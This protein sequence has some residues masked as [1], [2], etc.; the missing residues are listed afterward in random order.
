[1]KSLNWIKACTISS[2]LAMLVWVS[3]VAAQEN[4]KM[5]DPEVAH[6]AVTANQI[7]IDHASIAKE[8][9]KNAEVLQ[10]AETMARDHKAVI[11]QAVALVQKLGVTPEDNAV[12]QKL[13]ADAEAARKMLRSKSGKSFDKAYIDNE[14]VYHRAVIAAVEGLLIPEAENAQLK[15]LLQSVL[16]ALKAHLEHAE[17]V[18]KQIAKK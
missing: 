3:P 17:M 5:T 4:Q 15:E 14:I 8:K 6:A 12:S 18:Q 13:I 7:D 10:F 11:N 2:V 1:M 9:S 16:P